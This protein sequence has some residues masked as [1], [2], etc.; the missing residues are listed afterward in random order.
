MARSSVLMTFPLFD[1]SHNQLPALMSSRFSLTLLEKNAC[2]SLSRLFLDTE[3]TTKEINTIA[4]SLR[5]LNIPSCT[6][7][8]I[9]RHDVFPILYPNLLSS[10]GVW[11]GFDEDWLL[12]QVETR[13]ATE[14]GWVKGFGETIL[15]LTI[16]RI[17]A[18]LWDQVVQRL[19][20]KL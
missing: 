20:G 9:L 5:A 18:T 16:G 19:E 3:K 1:H 15:W 6:L 11:Q 7:G 2:I 14:P 8:C 10:T 17:V 12:G 4:T 13:R